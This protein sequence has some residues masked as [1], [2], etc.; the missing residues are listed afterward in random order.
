MIGQKSVEA[1]IRW[2]LCSRY[3]RNHSQLDLLVAKNPDTQAFF[4]AKFHVID[5]NVLEKMQKEANYPLGGRNLSKGVRI[6]SALAARVC[7]R[8]AQKFS[9]YNSM[10]A[11]AFSAAWF[12]SVWSE[13]CVIYPIRHL[14]RHIHSQLGNEIIVIPIESGEIPCLSHW[15]RSQLEPI[16]LA[17][18][19]RRRGAKAFLLVNSEEL[20]SQFLAG[21]ST[22]DFIADPAWWKSAG[23]AK[24]PSQKMERIFS[25]SGM[26]NPGVALASIGAAAV[27]GN[28]RDPH[29]SGDILL[30]S[31]EDN[32]EK[33]SVNFKM[34]K[35]C[36]DF[37]IFSPCHEIP[38]LAVGFFRLV[39]TISKAALAN[40]HKAV[41][42][43]GAREAHISDHLF[44]ES[45][46]IGHAVTAA[47][48]KVHLWPHS[49][50]AVHVPFHKHTA[51]G[52]VVAMTR[53]SERSWATVVN[54]DLIRVD[55][56][57]MLTK[58]YGA[59]SYSA[60]AP[61][62][63]VVFAGAHQLN[64]MPLLDYTRQEKALH[65][66]FNALHSLPSRFQVVVKPKA[67]WE[68]AEWI[69][70]FFPLDHRFKFSDQA[71]AD[72]DFPN[73]LF[74]SVSLGTTALLEGMG[75]GIPALIVRD[76]PIVDYTALD[77]EHFQVG[78]L[79]FVIQH[80][81]ACQ[82]KSHY[83]MMAERNLSWYEKETK[84]PDQ[85]GHTAA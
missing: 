64:R 28:A 42:A 39:G 37:V 6:D 4:K 25:S 16:V 36:R 18:E 54:P 59:R 26:R 55:S 80:I 7:R 2:F 84:F 85:R 22:L 5:A 21:Q 49:S 30:W 58:A 47:G 68:P 32:G 15:A 70:K 9:P 33:L 81:E 82:E 72:L 38:D 62:H 67:Y 8:L 56:S 52:S 63:I 31:Q 19:L 11:Q 73:M 10:D 79:E 76:F 17:G 60:D 48:G 66:F 29:A 41:A 83:L 14:A 12:F 23:A 35:N 20:R 43:T 50:N 46:L 65:R 24:S 74:V 77:A 61:I 13:I 27:V 34:M 53:S 69:E 45:A 3:L 78:P 44:F 51:I 71:T 57:L 1:A 40:A 75:R